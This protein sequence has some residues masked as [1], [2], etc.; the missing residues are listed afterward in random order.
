MLAQR[1]WFPP[2]SL[3]QNKSLKTKGRGAGLLGGNRFL[4]IGILYELSAF[5]TAIRGFCSDDA[6]RKMLK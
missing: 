1:Q 6:R 4:P 3:T 2:E 5:A